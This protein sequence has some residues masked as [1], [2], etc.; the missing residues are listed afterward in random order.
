[1]RWARLYMSPTLIILGIVALLA[2]AAVVYLIVP[3]ADRMLWDPTP[4]AKP[5]SDLEA[6][7][8]RLYGREGCWYCHTQQVR[9]VKADANLGP[10][11]LPGDYVYD[12]PAF[13]GSERQGP[14]L[15]WVG[16]RLPDKNYHI[17]HLKNPRA[18]MPGSIMPA[19]DHLPRADL[20]A[21]AAYLVSLKSG[22]RPERDL[23]SRGHHAHDYPP[24]R[25]RIQNPVAFSRENLTAGKRLYDRECA[26]CHG[27]GGRGSGPAEAVDFTDT[28]FMGEAT[29][30]YLF[31]KISEGPR[32]PV[33][34]HDYR[35]RLSARG[36]WQI[37][38]YL[39]SFAEGLAGE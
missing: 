34:G 3:T 14:D 28:H 36:R 15:A 20:E 30:A 23:A 10:I 11:S 5:Y 38:H 27:L 8:K 17:V 4:R 22:S 39:R 12:K 29:D 19:F 16:D 1:M 13:L 26:R 33:A 31:W 21:L 24:R 18:T 9:P 7:G 37:V 35:N 2:F 6:R 32:R 25:Y